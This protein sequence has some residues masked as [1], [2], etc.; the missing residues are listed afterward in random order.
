MIRLSKLSSVAL[1]LVAACGPRAPFATPLPDLDYDVIF[2]RGRV[3]DGTGAPAFLAEVAVR[4]DLIVAVSRTPL[5]R[6]A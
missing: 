3:L 4:G 5:P 2:V 1:L 6:G